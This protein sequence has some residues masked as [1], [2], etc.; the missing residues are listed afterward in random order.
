M[1]IQQQDCEALEALW[2][3]TDGASWGAD[4]GARWD[5]LISVDNSS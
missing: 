3:S 5:T 4:L 1:G 2:I